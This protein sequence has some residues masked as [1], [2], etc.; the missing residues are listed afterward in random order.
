MIIGLVFCRLNPTHDKTQSRELAMA[1][2]IS[3]PNSPRTIQGLSSGQRLYLREDELDLGLEMVFSAGLALKAATIET[4]A[5]HMLS[6]TQARALTALL[7][8]PQGVMALTKLL[9]VTKQAAIKTAQEL[10][11]RGLVEH[12]NDLCDGRRRTLILTDAGELIARELAADLRS[13]LASAYRKAGGES[14][15]GCDAVLA[16]IALPA[17]KKGSLSRA[18]GGNS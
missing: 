17:M 9:D 15:A 12:Q 8:V 6:W 14:V 10:Q 13:I 1:V 11:H 5:K 4:R 3:N 16:A 2:N 18:Q 7:R